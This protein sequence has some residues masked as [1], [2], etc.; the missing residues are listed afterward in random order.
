MLADML[1]EMNR[2][3]DALVQ[4][5]QALKINPNRFDSVYGAGRA[6]EMAKHPQEAATYFQRLVQVCAGSR[7]TRPEL[8]YAS[9][10]LSEVATKQFNLK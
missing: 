3:E 7:S 8:A 10:F 5:R 6:A 2:P 1:L 4:Y 9:R